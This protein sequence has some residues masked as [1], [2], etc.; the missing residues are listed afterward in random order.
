MCFKKIIAL[1]YMIPTLILSGC[2]VGDINLQ[3]SLESGSKTPVALLITPANSTVSAG[4]TQQMKAEATYSNSQTEDV[5]TSSDVTWSSSNDNVATINSSGLVTAIA[6][7]DVKISATTATSNGSMSVSTSL[8]VLSAPSVQSLAIIQQNVQSTVGLEA[9]YTAEAILSNGQHV[10]VTDDARVTWSVTDNSVASVSNAQGRKGVVTMLSEGQTQVKASGSIN[11]SSFGGASSLTVNADSVTVTSISITNVN[12][13][14]S[15]GTDVQFNAVANLSNGHVYTITDQSGLIWSVS[16]SEIAKISNETETKGLATGLSAGTTSVRALITIDGQNFES[17]TNLTVKGDTSSNLSGLYVQVTDP[18]ISVGFSTQATVQAIFTDQ[19]PPQYVTAN[20]NITWSVADPSIATVSNDVSDKGLVTAVSEGETEVIAT[21]VYEGQSY[22][23]RAEIT[24]EDAAVIAITMSPLD[25]STAVGSNKQFTAT[26][27]LDNGKKKE[28]TNDDEM[29]WTVDDPT[30]ATISNESGS[31]G[32]LTALSPG[33]VTVTAM[34]SSSNE[35]PMTSYTSLSVM[36]DNS[37]VSIMITPSTDL[38]LTG[39]DKAFTATAVYSD[40]GTQDVTNLDSVNWSVDDRSVAVVNNLAGNKGM[41]TGVSD[42]DTIVHVEGILN[43]VSVSDDAKISDTEKSQIVTWGNKTA[44]GDFAYIDEDDIQDIY[45]N[46]FAFA[47][48]RKD[49]SVV[50]WGQDGFGGDSSSV[51]LLNNVNTIVPSSGAFAALKNDGSVIAWGDEGM[52]GDA[53]KVQSQLHNVIS[54]QAS[55]S[56]AFAALKADG[57]VVTWGAAESGGNSEGVDLTNVTQLFSN[58]YSFAA[59]KGDGSVVVW[60]MTDRGGDASSID[61]TNIETIY[62][63]SVAYAAL[64]TD[65]SVVTWGYA[66]AGG[67]SSDVNLNNVK[68]VYSTP[69]AFA[70]LKT[71]GTVVAWGVSNYG[72]QL[73]SPLQY[74]K[75]IFS[76]NSAFAALHKD[77][78][79][80]TWGNEGGDSSSVILKDVQ[81]IFSTG[82]AFAALKSDDSV[83]TWGNTANGGNSSNVSLQNINTIYSTNTAFA[84]VT[85]DEDVIVWGDKEAGSDSSS[86]TSQ[87]HDIKH[88]YSTGSAFA[89]VKA[90]L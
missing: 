27:F 90:K 82:S 20:E 77:N 57:T 69:L 70:A 61:L 36:D 88:I 49:G 68:Q 5:T 13:T 18:N 22:T 26:A 78:S 14:T 74:V 9:N 15:I 84:A 16:N 11:G 39:Q 40:G 58:N 37:D 89:A 41:V 8:K 55:S 71:D 6:Q 1:G 59:M 48:V 30:I 32:L 24:V 80:T 45:S 56:G 31:K 23:S 66:Q 53:S 46:N 83:I 4:F 64:K 81:D 52:G 73:T 21:G 19:S 65:G 47:A 3:E 62:S 79:V 60:G 63:N 17:N 29:L 44:G 86:V 85:N 75:T 7:G 12:E 50:T 43:G 87:L 28:V 2:N 38:T 54:I 76:T 67:D 72:G 51:H 42:G 33:D 34:L 35:Q 10:D 25:D